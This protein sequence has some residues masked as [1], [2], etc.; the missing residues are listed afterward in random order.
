VT[1]LEI[2]CQFCTTQST[3]L[4]TFE[5]NG[6]THIVCT[7]CAEDWDDPDGWVDDDDDLEAERRLMM[8]R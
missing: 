2:P 6:D 8:V 4:V 3:D 7:S 1:L 5:A